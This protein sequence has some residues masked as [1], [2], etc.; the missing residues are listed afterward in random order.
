MSAR[1]E[2][3][4]FFNIG[5]VTPLLPF[6]CGT[7][8]RSLYMMRR[9]RI[10]NYKFGRDL[11]DGGG[12]RA[13]APRLPGGTP[14]V[15][16]A[17]AAR[18][19]PAPAAPSADYNPLPWL[20]RIWANGPGPGTVDAILTLSGRLDI[21]TV[22]CVTVRLGCTVRQTIAVRPVRTGSRV[23]VRARAR[24]I[25][26][27]RLAARLHRKKGIPFGSVFRLS[28]SLRASA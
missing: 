4:K 26:D 25:G 19:G 1:R 13:C 18:P 22:R 7:K 12:P 24:G 9:G 17:C 14:R 20:L 11:P 6:R 28:R 23:R 5:N 27:C 15:T 16:R 21:G 3:V 10:P 2:D 8:G